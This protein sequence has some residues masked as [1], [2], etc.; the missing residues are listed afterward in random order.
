MNA[1]TD[2]WEKA[3]KQDLLSFKKE[4]IQ[5]TKQFI[6]QSKFIKSIYLIKFLSNLTKLDLHNYEING[7]SVISSLKNLQVVDLSL[8]RIQNVSA[9]ESLK[10]LTTLNLYSNQIKSCNLI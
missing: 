7:I 8:N 9:L 10:N 3:V 5:Q 6:L 4:V 2:V 1:S